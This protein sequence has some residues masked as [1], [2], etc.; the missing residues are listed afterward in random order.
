MRNHLLHKFERA[1]VEEARANTSDK[2][3]YMKLSVLVMLD[4]GLS[5][6]VVSVSL[7][8]SLGT[9]N[10]C[11][12]KYEFA[13]LDSYLD[14]HYVPY[15]GKL[16]WEQLSLLE[17]EVQNGL[18]RTC[19]EVG[20]WIEQRFG[21]TYSESALRSIL[22]KLGFVYKK[23]S[24]V[25]GKADVAEQEGFIKVLVDFL[26][27]TDIQSEVVCFI[28]AV[29]P[30]HNTRPDYAWIK[31]GQDK[32]IRTNSGRSRININGAMNAHDPQDVTIIEA[33]CIDADATIELFEK[34]QAKY[35]HKEDIWLIG[36]NARY[37]TSHK[38][39]DW[40]RQN[41]K[42]QLLHLPPYSPNLNLIERMWKFLR[43]KVI[44]L[45]YYPKFEAF[46]RSILDFFEN[47]EQYKWELKTL[48]SP[49]FQRFSA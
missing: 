15:Q 48:M 35:A 32:E 11:K 19:A 42:V 30:Q 29:H 9:V 2:V 28:D 49:N 41:P 3:A 21:I 25:P 7:G 10:K 23:T 16:D 37:Y 17:Q 43:K 33:D 24:S 38:V 36:D 44:N 39:Q 12:H 47:L 14:T 13:G 40:L 4:E 6:E 18:Y 20:K 8:I 27:K 26:E 1:F 22:N 5:Q 31:Q 34:I 45:H 46:R